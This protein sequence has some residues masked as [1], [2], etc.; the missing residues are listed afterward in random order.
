MSLTDNQHA[1]LWDVH[2]N[3]NDDRDARADRL[4]MKPASV[5]RATKSLIDAGLMTSW[6]ET[7][8]EGRGALGVRP[9]V[10]RH[11]FS[12]YTGN[13]IVRQRWWHPLVGA[14]RKRRDVVRAARKAG[15]REPVLPI[16]IDVADPP[17]SVAAADVQ[18]AFPGAVT[19]T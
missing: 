6:G 10:V 9:K 13:P 8:R 19:T 17:V 18:R 7:T 14:R 15:A 4:G 11:V 12:L 16:L 1:V 2:R 3:P 5:S